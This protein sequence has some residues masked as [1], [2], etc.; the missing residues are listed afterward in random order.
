[1]MQS[2]FVKYVLPF[3][4]ISSLGFSSYHVL[5]SEPSVEKLTPP[6]KPARSAY[7]NTVAAAGLVE[8]RSENFAIGAA[9]PGIVLEVYVPSS[10]V[11]KFV[12]KGTPLFRVDDR[13]LKAQ[14]QM[15]EANLKAAQAQLAKLEAMPRS[16]EVP[17]AE[18]KVG[19]ALANLRLTKDQAER[20]RA[21][22]LRQATS[23]EE[24][25]QKQMNL[26]MGKY[27]WEQA[28]ADL[29]LLKAGAWQPDKAVSRAA[30]ELAQAQIEQTRTEIERAAVRAPIDGH[31][32]QVSVRPG[33]YVAAQSGQALV[34]M[35]DLSVHH[36]RV[37]VDEHDIPRFQPG[38]AARAFLRGQ[39][40]RELKLS[41]VRVEEYVTP[42]KSL[43]G[44]NTERVD[45]R[46][47]QVIYAVETK[48]QPI[49]IG[50]QLDVFIETSISTR[51]AGDA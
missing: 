29:E 12:K 41:F 1:M 10:E 33:E 45:T 34:L 18:A 17:P 48:D 23:Q 20:A 22:A 14:L 8:A 46:V 28:N 37:D 47:L 38:A 13:H 24:F 39:T 31:V 9:I 42:K 25:Y 7:T 26:E 49:Y 30:V 50:Q 27:Q 11:G 43:T 3:L 16:E 35:G 15:Q 51:W 4:A 6:A 19:A 40:Q 5:H 32:L 2:W 36:V 44:D 21:L